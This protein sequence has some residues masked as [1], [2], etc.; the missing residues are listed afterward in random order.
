[1]A[2]NK[3]AS[4]GK[5]QTNYFPFLIVLIIIA[6]AAVGAVLV[7][8]SR[9]FSDVQRWVLIG[10]IIAFPVFGILVALFGSAFSEW[11]T[12]REVRK[13]SMTE[14]RR[15]TAWDILPPEMQKQKLTAEV[16]RLAALM[17]IP[18]EQLS[19]LL[20]AYIVAED[21]ALRQIQFEEN[22]P[23]MRHVSIG[24]CDYEAILYNEEKLICMDVSFLVAP[25][26]RQEKISEILKRVGQTKIVMSKLRPELKV[27]LLLVLVTQLDQEEEEKLRESLGKNRFPNTPVSV[28]IRLKDFEKLQ[29]HYAI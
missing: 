27:E 25:E 8:A 20:S 9:N 10:F 14:S 24:G 29:K 13:I 28:D 22:I 17:D 15:N 16:K 2:V 1:M 7:F 19:D 5:R 3:I 21:L 12:M 18:D 11:L 23:L 26:L 6:C 4:N